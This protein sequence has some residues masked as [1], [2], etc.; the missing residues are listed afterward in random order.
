MVQPI[1]GRR[2]QWKEPQDN[3]AEA[4]HA[5]WY[6]Y[7]IERLQARDQ[8]RQSARAL[9]VRP[10]SATVCRLCGRPGGGAHGRQGLGRC[11]GVPAWPDGRPALVCSG[12]RRKRKATGSLP[13]S[14]TTVVVDH[15]GVGGHAAG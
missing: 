10:T 6:E 3:S 1:T 9:G 14:T 2:G 13:F 7:N 11:V 15:A 8:W 12:C 4:V 5:R